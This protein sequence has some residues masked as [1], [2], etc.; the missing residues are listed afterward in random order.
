MI[1]QILRTLTFHSSYKS[2]HGNTN[3]NL[4]AVNSPSSP[5]PSFPLHPLSIFFP[6]SPSHLLILS[7][8][9][10][11]YPLLFSFPSSHPLSFFSSRSSP[12]HLLPIFF[13][14]I[15]SLLSIHHLPHLLPLIF[16]SSPFYVL[17]SIFPSSSPPFSLSSHRHSL[18][19]IPPIL[20]PII[21]QYYTN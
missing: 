21:V 19:F 4:I 1:K 8:S 18:P 15:L 10:P 11:P 7:P 13:P 3:I 12:F 9:S 6:S 20:S 2:C 5:H 16:S 17:P 14:F